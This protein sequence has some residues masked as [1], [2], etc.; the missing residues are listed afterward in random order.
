MRQTPN[1]G[2]HAPV[3]PAEAGTPVGV[4]CP[5]FLG[6]L[7]RPSG[8]YSSSSYSKVQIGSDYVIYLIEVDADF[9]MIVTSPAYVAI[10]TPGAPGQI[11]VS[12]A[13]PVD[14]AGTELDCSFNL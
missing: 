5:A 11:S 10:D 3:V 7:E 1:P 8:P 4:R 12:T 6:S 13:V 14:V 2:Q 9:S